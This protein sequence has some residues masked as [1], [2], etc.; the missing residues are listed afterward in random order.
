LVLATPLTVCLVV[1]G[2]HVER[3]SF[4]DVMF[5][6]RPALSPPEIF[7][8]RML[9]GDPAE[10]AEKAEQFLKERSL[11]T[12]Y[13]DV[14]LSGLQLAQSDLEREVLNDSRIERIRD[15]VIEFTND[16]ADQIDE[17]PPG[18]PA[19]G[20]AETAA[21]VENVAPE[22]R[23]TLAVVQQ[24]SL[25]TQWQGS[26]P[27]V[28]IAGRTPLDEAAGFM[29]AHLCN[30]HGLP[31]RV[32]QAES[33]S[34]SNIFRLEATGIA[35]VCLSYLDTQKPA[36]LHYSVK[37]LRRKLPQAIIML[38]C[39]KVEGTAEREALRLSAKADLVAGTLRDAVMLCLEAAKPADESK[40]LAQS[41]ASAAI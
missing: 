19:P 5:G 18:D 6:D 23:L 29:F 13:D 36:H 38:A 1:L 4:L 35:L 14:A 33:L 34:T 31:A 17:E 26:F 24:A 7:Y 8:Q 2:R 30:A 12:Y 10:A 39:W 11:S 3:L 40:P 27:V 22:S 37:R 41:P 21:A 28:C 15:T 16:L 20:D 9:A 32:E 25:P